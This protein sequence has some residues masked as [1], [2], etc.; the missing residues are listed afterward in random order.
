M[1]AASAPTRAD[2]TSWRN[3]LFVVF[4][5]CGIGFASWAARIPAVSQSLDLRTDELGV[6]LF[7]LAV[8]SIF[9]LLASGHLVAR[10]GART[11][12]TWTLTGGPLGLA[13]AAFGATTLQQFAVTFVGLMV[14]GASMGICDVAMNVSGAANERMLQRTVMPVFHAFFS[15]GTMLG[16]GLGALAQALSIPLDVHIATLAVLMIATALATARYV[17]PEDFAADGDAP[18]H[19][20]GDDTPRQGWRERLGA[21]RDPGTILI[22]LIVLGMAFAEGSANDWLSYAM[23]EGHDTDE[24]TGAIVFGVFVTAMTGG[25]LGGVLL[26]DRYGRV[27]VLRVSAVFATVGLLML[28]FSPVVWIAIVGVVLWGLGAAL[29]FPVGMSAAAD[30]PRKAAGRVSAVATIG[31][32]AFLVGPPSIGFLGEQFGILNGLLV[33]LILVAVAGLV[34]HAAREPRTM[35]APAGRT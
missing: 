33:V 28:I 7:G 34:S 23:V 1:T 21:W 22:G 6:L 24:V 14:Y 5:L 13:V 8:G 30:D 35:T 20:S 4:G 17:R 12:I 32:L 16:A 18:L 15:F 31:Y 26:L 9:G 11:I 29:G 3:A 27:P 10:H 2:Q 25:R 19:R